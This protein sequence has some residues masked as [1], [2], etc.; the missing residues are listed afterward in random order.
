MGVI[1]NFISRFRESDKTPPK[2]ELAVT[3]FSLLKGFQFRDFNPDALVRRKGLKIYEQM[4]QDDQVKS[5]L[6]L[7]KHAVVASGWSIVPASQ[8]PRDIEIAEFVEFVLH[9]MRGTINNFLFQ[10]MTALDFGYSISEIIWKE[11]KEGKNVGMIGIDRIKGKNPRMFDFKSDEFGNLLPKGIVQLN[12]GFVNGKAGRGHEAH[13]PTQKFIIYS[14][15]KEFSNW[16]GKSDLRAAYPSW[17]SKDNTLKFWSMYLERFGSPIAV[18]KYNTATIDVQNQ[19]KQ[20]LDSLQSKSSIVHSK[21][22]FELDF[23]ES[24]R[25][26]ASDYEAA[27]NF[28]NRSIARAI[29]VPDRV[30]ETGD[31]GAFA[32]A[33][34]HF[35]IFLI[36]VQ[37]LR[38]DL[39]EIVMEEQLIRRLIAFNFS[40]VEELPKFKFKPLT[41]AQRVELATTFSD[42]VQKGA[43]LP[44]PQ[45]EDHLREALHF[46][47]RE[48]GQEPVKREPNKTPD[49]DEIDEEKK[50][51]A[52]DNREKTEPEKRVNFQEVN[53]QTEG[54]EAKY[55]ELMRET[56]TKQR[57]ALTSTVAIKQ[58]TGKLTTGWIDTGL[59]LKFFGEIKKEARAMFDESYGAG[60][61]DGRS[62]IPKKFAATAKPGQEVLPQKALDYFDGKSNFIVD[63]IREPLLLSTKGILYNAIRKGESVP[64]TTKKLQDAYLP[65]LAEGDVIIDKKQ[66][67]GFRLEAITRTNVNEAYNY[68]RRAV[69]EAPDLEGFIIG[70][71][72]SEILDDRTTDVS[73]FVDGKNIALN[74]P[75]LPELTYPLH[76]NERG[77]FVYLTQDDKPVTF[78][79][80]AEIAQAVN[81]KGI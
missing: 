61:K 15:Q 5:S 80:D 57:D 49:E 51:L 71:Q 9:K 66:I 76:F 35:D 62:E 60:K 77:V 16:Y 31:K 72:F 81:M 10:A 11:Y 59:T 23:L 32:Q 14:Y 46:P 73:R 8:D 1:D 6:E 7:K 74:H 36:I 27:L 45:D 48:E 41:S 63:G 24:K 56:L 58:N 4:R 30:N 52:K 42:A 17:W 37:K 70:Y 19:L 69:G 47:E 12:T 54:L 13:L 43:V 25:R 53:K 64:V 26:S 50:K 29:L 67:K 78:M 79:S 28:Y 44:T 21:D 40:N 55:T 20:V 3:E 18:G 65:Y 2:G 33:K 68:G 39:E 75:S 38:G 22:D 34:V